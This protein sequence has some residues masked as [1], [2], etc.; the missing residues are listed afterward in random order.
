MRFAPDI[1]FATAGYPEKLARRLRIFNLTC[2]ASS[3]MWLCFAV[4][5][6]A[7][8]GFSRL[9]AVDAGM[10]AV[11]VLIPSL[12]RFGPMAAPYTFLVIS[13]AATFY[14]CYLLG[15]DSGM[16]IQYLAYSG[17]SVLIAGWERWHAAALVALLGATLIIVLEIVAPRDGGLIGEAGMLAGFIGCV[18]GT[19]CVLCAVVFYA[20]REAASAELR[21][22]REFE[23]SETLLANILPAS[24]A[25]R[26]KGGAPRGIADRY[27]AAS[28]LFADIVGFTERTAALQPAAVVGFLNEMFATFDGLVE[29]HGL[30]KIKTTGDSYMVVS[31]V[32]VARPDHAEALARFALVMADAATRIVDPNGRPLELRIGLSAGPVVA[33]VVGTR[34][35]F[36]DVWGDAVNVA[37]RMESTGLAGRIQVSEPFH[38]AVA[39]R[40]R[41]EPRGEI[42][43]KGKGRMSTWFLIGPAD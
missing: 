23:R 14:V 28:I 35:F 9:V 34:K 3:I 31:G 2:A 12:H 17:G 8:A 5:Y 22:E 24:I 37:S 43:V 42:D 39:G 41:C 29:R 6:F 38:R 33:G 30:E 11:V 1:G 19:S 27:E 16:Q 25:A 32:P 10:A 7:S 36:Y 21:A 18:V 4:A 20:V 15:T 40:F 13:Y 26:L